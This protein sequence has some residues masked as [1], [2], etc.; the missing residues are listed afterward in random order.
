[1]PWGLR[2][3]ASGMAELPSTQPLSSPQGAGASHRQ[4]IHHSTPKDDDL[5]RRWRPASWR[6][7]PPR[8]GYARPAPSAQYVGRRGDLRELS[9]VNLGSVTAPLSGSRAGCLPLLR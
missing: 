3:T 2:K 4:R 9:L 6:V 1:L 5:Y 7:I 8:M